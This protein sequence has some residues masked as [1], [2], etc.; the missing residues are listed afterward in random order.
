MKGSAMRA[1]N[2]APT[3]ALNAFE[4]DPPAFEQL[5]QQNGFR[6]WTAS[7]L[8]KALGYDSTERI[9]NA[10]NKAIG[11]CMTNN[12]SVAENI[13]CLTQGK[14]PEYKLSRFACYLT[15]MNA[16][17]RNPLVAK[18]Q[19]FFA[20]LAD[21]Y[22]QSLNQ[23]IEVERLYERGEISKF[24]KSIASTAFNHGVQNYAHFQN[25]GY[26]GMYNMPI[27]DVKRYKNSPQEGSLL[28]RMGGDELAANHFRL[29]MTEAKIRNEAINGQQPLENAAQTVG[30]IVR[31]ATIKA[32]GRTPESLPLSLPITDTKKRVKATQKAFL[33]LDKK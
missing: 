29:R 5:A 19:G 1:K 33:K 7:N 21:E 2:N 20:A 27:W 14:R 30:Q 28:D 25:A 31:E 9:V 16:D 11:V 15:V 13:E 17:V 10:I 3:Q 32:L 18:A 6:Y 22:W 4:G 8:A 26:L 24:E 12:F 23:N